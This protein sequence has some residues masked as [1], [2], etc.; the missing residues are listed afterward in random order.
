VQVPM[1]VNV[2]YRLKIDPRERRYI[3]RV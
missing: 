2:G 1:F 3:S